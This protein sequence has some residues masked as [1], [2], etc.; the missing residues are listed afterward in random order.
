MEG[1]EVIE[2]NNRTSNASLKAINTN[3][4][5]TRNITSKYIIADTVHR[6]NGL[7]TFETLGSD[8]LMFIKFRK[9]K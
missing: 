9:R 4:Q 6:L 7:A 8:F 2:V 3:N 5:E 1:Y